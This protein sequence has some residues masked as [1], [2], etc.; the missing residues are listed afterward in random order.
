MA[1]KTFHAG[2]I[3]STL[4][5]SAHVD[6]AI[7]CL[8]S[9]RRRCVA[10]MP[11][12]IRIH[13]DGS[14]RESDRDKLMEGLGRGVEIIRREQGDERMR[15]RLHK[16]P[17]LADLRASFPLALKLLDA[18]L[19]DES[20]H[21]NFRFVDGDILFLQRLVDPLALP[22][23]ADAVFMQDRES[24]YSLRSWQLARSRRL[25]LPLKINSGIISFRRRVY[26]LDFLEWFVGQKSHCAIPG[27]VEQTAWAAMGFRAP[28]GCLVLDPAR[29]RVMRKYEDCSA[30]AIGH[31]TARTRHLLA[32]FLARNPAADREDSEPVM[33]AQIAPDECRFADLFRYEVRR[34]AAR[35]RGRKSWSAARGGS[36]GR[37]IATVRGVS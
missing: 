35:P 31:F 4:L 6:M 23:D 25:R 5:C 29:V 32:D 16:H 28:Q 17:R 7:E 21:D 8:N 33:L 3:V 14:L 24:S 13:D 9:V 36:S 26:D 11:I 12:G 34:L 37:S 20:S 30:L 27:M 1:E 2:P 10:A 22:I 19:W 15:E 18:P